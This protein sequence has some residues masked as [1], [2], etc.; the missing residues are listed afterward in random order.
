MMRLGLLTILILNSLVLFGQSKRDMIGKYR[1]S[2]F[3]YSYTLIL[4]DGENYEVVERSD[5]QKEITT[6]T[7]TI[8]G[9]AIRLTPKTKINV[10][11][12]SKQSRETPTGRIEQAVVIETKDILTLKLLS[13]DL[14]LERVK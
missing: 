9:Q 2:S 12:Y 5:L 3:M 7:W 6:G 1:H 11:A 10:D 14:K 8:H 13:G 4:K